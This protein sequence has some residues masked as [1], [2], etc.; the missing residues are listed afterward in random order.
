M[1]SPR[2]LVEAEPV[3]G[4]A[5]PLPQ[6]VAHHA[7]RVLRLRGGSPITLFTGRGGEYAA[8]LRVDGERAW[9]VTERFEP[10]ERESPLAV[11]LVQAW[12]ATDKLDWIVE[13]AVE[14]GVMALCFVPAARSVVRLED[15]RREKRLHRL[16]EIAVAACCQS[17]RNR[18]PRVEAA[19]TLQRGL[20]RALQD[21][22]AG[23][24]LDPESPQGL[25]GAAP[26]LGP[27][28]LAVG[29]E[30]GFADDERSLAVRLGYRAVNLGPR[31]LR[32]ET[33]GVAA[34]AA[35]QALAGDLR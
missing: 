20:D 30:G 17:G 23:L 16:G 21:G 26:F 9:A 5:A 8:R 12:V 25:S 4:E 29:P 32:T 27:L 11:T 3:V 24:L 6:A 7:L 31:I 22:A 19:E 33:A 15:S 2:F 35:L 14:L 18:V 1:S 13:K 28:A 34:L 10:I